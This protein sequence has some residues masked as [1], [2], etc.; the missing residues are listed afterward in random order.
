[1]TA[2]LSARENPVPKMARVPVLVHYPG[3]T[4][5]R[6]TWATD[7]EPPHIGSILD[8]MFER[9][10][11]L[12]RQV[13]F[14]ARYEASNFGSGYIDSPHLLLGLLRK[15]PTLARGAPLETIREQIGVRLS[16]GKQMST[17]VD[18][19]LSRDAKSALSHAAKEAKGLGEKFVDSGHIVL[20]LLRVEKSLAAEVLRENGVTYD[21]FRDL[22][23][24][25]VSE[26]P[27]EMR[28]GAWM[29]DDES[30]AEPEKAIPV[31]A[32][33]SVVTVV[34]RLEGLIEGAVKHLGD[35]SEVDAVRPLA[36]KGWSRA[37]AL[38]HLVDW[39]MAH[40]QWF[41]RALTESKLVTGGY[42]QE[43]WSRVQRYASYPW[44]DL[45]SLWEEVNRL[46][47]HVIAQITEEKLDTP[48]QIGIREPVPLEKLADDY[49]VYCENA[50]GQIL[51][52]G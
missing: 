1:M 45:V 37:E 21:R 9:Y 31:A 8:R 13:V 23:K 20:G 51:A 22:I 12:A 47:V 49:L 42:P 28:H 38:G 25:Q 27:P 32:A 44:S 15:D 46:L 7:Y 24:D 26:P 41:A 11:M 19:P 39:A 5:K 29:A 34:S 48:C 3:G 50:M 6:S 16:R 35:Y 14:F 43:S 17:S 18:L 33:P 52:R 36:E 40:H 10:T 4:A 30:V 2:K